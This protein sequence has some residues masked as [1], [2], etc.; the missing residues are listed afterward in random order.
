MNIWSEHMKPIVETWNP[1]S[2]TKKKTLSPIYKAETKIPNWEK[3][4]SQNQNIKHKKSI[5]QINR[6]LK[7]KILVLR[8]NLKDPFVHDDD[9]NVETPPLKN[10]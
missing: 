10:R 2:A 5:D 4:K 3:K 1:V 6:V 8:R 9:G 7:P